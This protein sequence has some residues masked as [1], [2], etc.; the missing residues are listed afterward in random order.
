[1]ICELATR[2]EPFGLGL[3]LLPFFFAL[4]VT[5]MVLAAQSMAR[6]FDDRNS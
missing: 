5:G 2:G 1:M 6:W 4:L 3:A